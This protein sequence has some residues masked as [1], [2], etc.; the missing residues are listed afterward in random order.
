MS[1]H[2]MDAVLDV[3]DEAL[4]ADAADVPARVPPVQVLDLLD[5]PTDTDTGA[6]TGAE[7]A[8]VA[9]G[10]LPPP[11]P[12]LEL[13]ILS[14]MHAGA[15]APLHGE[16]YLLGALD[17]CDFVFEDAG[18]QPHHARLLRGEADDA[19]WQLKWIAQDGEDPVLAPMRLAQG[20]AVPLGPIVLAVD[21]PG[22]PWPTLE[23]LVL[24]PHAPALEPSLP[25][26]QDLMPAP[27]Q[28][29]ALAARWRSVPPGRVAVGIAVATLGLS[30]AAAL[31]V[32]PIGLDGSLR[33]SLIGGAEV[34]ATQSAP[35]AA[36]A[37]DPAQRQAIEAALA[38][39]GLAGR[40]RIEPVG[41]VW[42]VRAPVLG[43]LEAEAL[44]AALARLQPRPLLR[45]PTEHELR[46][47][48]LAA[49]PQLAGSHAAHVRLRPLGAGRFRLE[50]R[51]AN[52]QERDQFLRAVAEA[53]PQAAWEHAVLTSEEAAAGLLAELRS[54]GWQASGEWKDGA[55]QVQVTLQQR[56]VPNWEQTLLAV[57]RSHAVPLR[58]AMTFAP[59]APTPSPAPRVAEA[60]LPFQIR[61]VVGGDM[62]YVLLADGDR[63]AQGGVWKGWRLASI[64]AAQ[65]VF[66]NGA[67][68]AVLTR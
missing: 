26:P 35:A 6:Q 15:R 63:L 40:A 10:P 33:D 48:V 49:L 53:L 3:M 41:A 32:W 60:S 23:Q 61:G 66:E 42:Q 39:R 45:L 8:A 59:G 67:Q 65:V 43:D 13:R 55:L 12:E 50:G 44:G 25:P 19:G 34:A 28:P 51:I 36:S 9:I 20:K 2:D 7:A 37:P 68:R 62:P 16:S 30:A 14:G 4:A 27:Q 21:V 17:D 5:S 46:D 29:R 58:A 1:G 38:S 57:N 52:A 18:V 31:A 54:R 11:L 56:D 47:E 24:V 22:A 64:S